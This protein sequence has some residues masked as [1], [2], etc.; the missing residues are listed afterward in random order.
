MFASTE[1]ETRTKTLATLTAP[2][3]G[4]YQRGKFRCKEQQKR[5]SV[6]GA[7]PCASLRGP[8]V[9]G[10][11][12]GKPRNAHSPARDADAAGVCT[13]RS[14]GNAPRPSPPHAP[15]PRALAH[16]PAQPRDAPPVLLPLPALG[17]RRMAFRPRRGPSL[18]LSLVITLRPCFSGVARRL[19]G[20][21]CIARSE[22]HCDP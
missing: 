12:R 5:P 22:H 16:T 1:H 7:R 8:R 2:V 13:S 19:R 3:S 20:S 9:H 6:D 17:R 15:V 4:V 11:S 21:N 18:A 10:R 14:A